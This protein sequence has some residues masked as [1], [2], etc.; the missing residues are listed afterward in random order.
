MRAKRN[1]AGRLSKGAGI[2]KE[3]AKERLKEYEKLEHSMFPMGTDITKVKLKPTDYELIETMAKAGW[4][5]ERICQFFNLPA[6]IKNRIAKDDVNFIAAIRA[7]NQLAVAQ[8]VNS[9]YKRATGYDYIEEEYKAN[10]N[11]E[12]KLVRQTKKHVIP[13]TAAAMNFLNNRDYSN[14]KIGKKEGEE[15]PQVKINVTMDGKQYQELLKSKNAQK[16]IEA[17]YEVVNGAPD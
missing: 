10:E 11:G 14:W 12:M 16:Q 1:A 3:A 5:H 6:K 4:E 8:V 7:G 17:K 2:Q 9:L 15:K 13:D